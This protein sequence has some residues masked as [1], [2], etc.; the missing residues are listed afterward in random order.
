[1][2]SI[3]S[4]SFLKTVYF[5][6]KMLPFNQAIKFPFIIGRK[7]HFISL[8]GNIKLLNQKLSSGII[9]IG[10]SKS[11]LYGKRET[12]DLHIDGTLVIDGYGEILRGSR[13]FIGENGKLSL[14]NGYFHFNGIRIMCANDIQINCPISV[15]QN[16]LITDSDFH[17]TIDTLTGKRNVEI[18]K[19]V[20]IGSH[21]WIS[22]DVTILKGT[23]T[24]NYCIIGAK[25]LLNKKY[26]IEENCLIAGVPAQLKLKNIRR[27]FNT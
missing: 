17:Y 2:K 1:M 16:T 3:L 23:E 20:I 11:V 25:S 22:M 6:F 19:P 21:N 14:M 10:L 15:G 8:K 4:C 27:D 7:T 12:V 5:N 13:I 9:K 24:P 18:T 26:N